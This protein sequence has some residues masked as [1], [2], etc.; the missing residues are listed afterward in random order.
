M[1][2]CITTYRTSYFKGD[3]IKIFSYLKEQILQ[4]KALLTVYECF[5]MGP[6]LLKSAILAADWV[7]VRVFFIQGLYGSRLPGMPA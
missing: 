4:S 7:G 6:S 1:G 5:D 2:I 3:L